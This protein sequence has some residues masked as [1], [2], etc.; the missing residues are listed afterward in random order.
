MTALVEEHLSLLHATVHQMMRALP[1]TV[2]FNDL[3]GE[4]AIALIE[5][6]KDWDPDIAAFSTYARCRIRGAVL[7]ELRR[8]GRSRSR[9]TTKLVDPLAPQERLEIYDED[10]RTQLSRLPA[11]ERTAVVLYHVHDLTYK[12]IGKVLGVC[13]QTVAVIVKRAARRLRRGLRDD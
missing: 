2:D 3:L 7:D 4:G 13:D 12:Q 5:A 9:L 8:Q 10:V 1:P 6:E 11:D